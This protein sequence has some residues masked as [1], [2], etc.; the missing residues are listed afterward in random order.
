MTTDTIK[1]IPQSAPGTQAAF[2]RHAK[3]GFRQRYQWAHDSEKLAR[4]MDS[5][6]TTIT[7]DRNTCMIDTPSIIAAWRAIGGKGKP[8]YKA[9]RALPV[10]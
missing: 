8:T 9:L 4:F 3:E 5:L 1:P 7:T 6:T 10:S 2:L